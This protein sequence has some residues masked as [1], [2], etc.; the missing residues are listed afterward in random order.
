[1]SSES[2]RPGLEVNG[3]FVVDSPR[4]AVYDFLIDTASFPVAD[5]AM[6]DWSPHGLMV[7]GTDGTMRR[8]VGGGMTVKT[9]WH[10]V[11]LVPGVRIVI[12]VRGMG[13]EMREVIEL[14]EAGAATE[15]RVLDSLT[16]TSLPGRLFVAASKGFVRRDIEARSG[17]LQAALGNGGASAGDSPVS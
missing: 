11:E 6:V 2:R 1:M 12:D 15:V 4:S 14:R 8:R 10:V 13:Y 7:V 9:T 5:A 17:R 3:S 16:G